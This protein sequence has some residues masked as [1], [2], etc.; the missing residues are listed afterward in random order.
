MDYFQSSPSI[1]LTV[2]DGIDEN[3]WCMFMLWI[4]RF[5]TQNN[6][7]KSDENADSQLTPSPAPTASPHPTHVCVRTARIVH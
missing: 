2:E 5:R 3:G 4:G 7:D 6:M 1:V